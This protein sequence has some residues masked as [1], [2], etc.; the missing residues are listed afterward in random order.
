MADGYWDCTTCSWQGGTA[1]NLVPLG[2]AR[3]QPPVEP[4]DAVPAQA[5]APGAE[6]L[7]AVST[8]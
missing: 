2:W 7:P 8:A 3:W 1:D 4:D 5:T 6:T